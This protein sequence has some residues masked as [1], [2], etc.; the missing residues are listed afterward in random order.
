MCIRDSAT[1]WSSPAPGARS[2]AALAELLPPAERAPG[3]GELQ[4]VAWTPR[5]LSI[6]GDEILR[7]ELSGWDGPEVPAVLVGG[8]PLLG[9]EAVA[10]GTVAGRTV[11][12]AEGERDLVVQTSR[13]CALAEGAVHLL[14]PR[15]ER[16]PD[17]REAVVLSSRPGDR[18]QLFASPVRLDEPYRESRGPVW[19][20]GSGIAPLP[21]ES[22]CGA[23]GRAVL[24]LPAEVALAQG[25]LFLQ[26]VVAPR[27]DGP[28]SPAGAFSTLLEWEPADGGRPR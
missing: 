28:D 7:V 26:A 20:D 12:N 15:L 13:G 25:K 21:G 27:G 9:V 10:P 19:L 2:A 23:D 11:A 4:I 22:T 3:A 17:S 6:L 1:I 14:R 24:A 16:A 18:V 8:A 5:R